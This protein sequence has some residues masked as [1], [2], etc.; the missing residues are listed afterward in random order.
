VSKHAGVSI[1]FILDGPVAAVASFLGWGVWRFG[2][3]DGGLALTVHN[4]PFAAASPLSP[5]AASAPILGMFRAVSELVLRQPVTVL[6]HACAATGA[7]PQCEFR[8]T[9]RKDPDFT[10]KLARS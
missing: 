9:A 10:E 8:V 2:R 5:T 4:S 7:V 3:D 6:E 1:A